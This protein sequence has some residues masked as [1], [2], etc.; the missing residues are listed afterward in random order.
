MSGERPIILVLPP[1]N[2]TPRRVVGLDAAPVRIGARQRCLPAGER[3]TGL[4]ARHP[5]A[6]AGAVH[7]AR[8]PG[9]ARPAG[10]GLPQAHD[11]GVPRRSRDARPGGCFHR[12]AVDAHE[13]AVRLSYFLW[14][15]MPDD[16]LFSAAESGK[17]REEEELLRQARRLLADPRGRA[18]TDN[19]GVQWLQLDRLAEARP[20]TEFFPSFNIQL[21]DAML[22]ETTAFF[23]NLRR[24]DRSLLE[25]LDADCR[26]DVGQAIV[27]GL[28]LVGLEDYL[29]AT[30]AH[31]VRHCHAVLA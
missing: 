26:L 29:R 18:L 24:E 22:A 2:R 3:L 13:L 8:A 23:D 1:F 12:A 15:T 4:G 28:C 10:D 5:A 11:A 17:L 31:R 14:S 27:E 6:D 21:K 30:V 9:A 19:F 7:A 20:T 16:E 25:L